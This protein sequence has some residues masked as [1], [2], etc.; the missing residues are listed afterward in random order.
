MIPHGLP[1]WYEATSTST[2][3]LPCSPRCSLLTRLR[4]RAL[5]L[6]GRSWRLARGTSTPYFRRLFVLYHEAVWLCRVFTLATRLS[7]TCVRWVE[8]EAG[9]WT[10]RL[11]FRCRS[12][13]YH[14]PA[15]HWSRW[16][17]LE[18]NEL[19]QLGVSVHFT[20]LTVR[21]SSR[22]THDALTLLTPLL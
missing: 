12:G 2:R 9:W 11:L 1:V 8:A 15:L 4:R 20:F 17:L 21:N 18:P 6:Y 22:I 19:V 5:L 13:G 14:L 16:K 3:R 7:G 10:S